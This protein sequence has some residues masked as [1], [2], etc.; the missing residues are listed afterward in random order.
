MSAHEHKTYLKIQKYQTMTLS[1][2]RQ[3]HTSYGLKALTLG[4][5]HEITSCSHM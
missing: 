3:F 4:H 1:F 5:V 2:S